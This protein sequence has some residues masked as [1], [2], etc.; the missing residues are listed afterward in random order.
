M[1][2]RYNTVACFFLGLGAG[3][4]AGILFAPR[5]GRESRQKIRD[6]AREG[7]S[8]ITTRA[9]QGGDYVSSKAR[10]VRDSTKALVDE[11]MGAVAHGKERV[12]A[13]VSAG[14]KVFQG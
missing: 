4:A 8:Q 7:A 9:R 11:G 6:A 10:E 1:F 13:A 3:V 5:S 12:A 14:R 2:E